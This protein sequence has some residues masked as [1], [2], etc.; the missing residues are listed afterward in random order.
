[1]QITEYKQINKQTNKKKKKKGKE[2]T[3]IKINNKIRKPSIKKD[4][5]GETGSLL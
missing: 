3:K 2:I 5:K 4:N 1:M